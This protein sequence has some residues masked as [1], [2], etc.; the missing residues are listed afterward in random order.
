MLQPYIV[1]AAVCNEHR[2]FETE[3]SKNTGTTKDENED[4][5]FA[6]VDSDGSWSGQLLDTSYDL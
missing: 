5:A 1:K 4:M 2:Q 6:E 3:Y